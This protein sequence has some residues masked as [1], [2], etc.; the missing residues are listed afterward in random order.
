MTAARPVTTKRWEASRDGAED[1]E[2]LW[3]VRARNPA[4]RLLAE[5]VAFVTANQE[6]AFCHRAPA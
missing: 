3:M 4:S 6:H 1:F 5:A 2:L